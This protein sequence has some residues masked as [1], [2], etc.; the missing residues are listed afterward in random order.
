MDTNFK[1]GNN[2]INIVVYSYTQRSLNRTSSFYAFN[3]FLQNSKYLQSNQF[4]F[5]DFKRRLNL[6]S[7]RTCFGF[8][9]LKTFSINP[10]GKNVYF[11][12]SKL[13]FLLFVK[14]WKRTNFE[15]INSSEVPS[16]IDETGVKRW[17]QE[18]EFFS[19]RRKEN[20]KRTGARW[21]E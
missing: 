3:A 17:K 2:L 19:F 4:L 1:K 16:R 11:D 10:S 9:R 21:G 5:E 12:F 8:F 7:E 18:L 14:K 20:Y 6:K 13:F 15:L